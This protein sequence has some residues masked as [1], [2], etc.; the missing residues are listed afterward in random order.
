[1]IRAIKIF[2]L[3]TIT[4]IIIQNGYSQI[5]VIEPSRH[6]IFYNEVYNPINVYLIKDSYNSFFLTTDNGVIIGDST[7]YKYKP[8]KVGYGNIY[9]K[10]IHQRDTITIDKKRVRIIDLPLPTAKVADISY[11]EISGKLF[12]AQIGVAVSYDNFDIDLHIVVKSFR[13]IIIR[14]DT[15]FFTKQENGYKFSDR[16]KDALRNLKNDDIV[17]I[18]SIIVKFPDDSKR[19]INSIELNIK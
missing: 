3:L 6:S 14:N 8:D 19:R 12:S 10:T 5:S 16:T 7:S 4:L 2:W 1:M 9:V 18:N 11:G 13:I 15:L 17:Y